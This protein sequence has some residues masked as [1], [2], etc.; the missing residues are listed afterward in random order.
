MCPKRTQCTRAAPKRGRSLTLHPQE[1]FFIELRSAA[2]TP[3]GREALRQRT[4]VEHGLAGIHNRQGDRARYRSQRKNLFDLRRYAALN[5]LSV[6]DHL[7][8]AA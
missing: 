5:N 8:R 4:N 7:R 6:I 3:A 2:R 1:R